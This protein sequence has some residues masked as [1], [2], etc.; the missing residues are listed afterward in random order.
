MSRVMRKHFLGVSDQVP[1]KQGSTATD[2][3]KMLEISDLG[4]RRIVV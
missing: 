3:G 4:R 2:D 1:H